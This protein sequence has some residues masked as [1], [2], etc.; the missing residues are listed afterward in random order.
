MRRRGHAEDLIRKVVY[1][2]PL[3][4]FSQCARFAHNIRPV[5]G[6]GVG[7]RVS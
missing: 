2:N 6:A 7:L 3:S 1:E 5:E 4:F